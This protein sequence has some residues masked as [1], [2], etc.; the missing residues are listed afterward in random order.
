MSQRTE[1]EDRLSFDADAALDRVQDLYHLP[2]LA[3]LLAYMLWIRVQSWERFFVNDRVLFNG[4]DA[5]YHFRTTTY[6]VRNWPFTMPFDP[7]TYFPYGT[8]SGQFGTFYDQ[9]VA[10]AA[11]VVGVFYPGPQTEATAVTLLFAPAVIGALT[12]IPGYYLGKHFGGRLGGVVAVIVLALTPGAFLWRSLV[13]FSDHHAAEALFQALAVL[14]V[15]VAVAVAE[16]DKPIYEQ[17]V[18]RDF[19]ALRGTLLYA[20]LAGVAVAT[21]VWVWPPG[22]L[23]VAIL[24]AFFLV[25]LLAT[26]LRGRS[27]EHVAI[28]GIVTLVVAALLVSIRVSTL[29]F[30]ATDFSL[31]QP[32]LLLALAAG[33]AVMIVLAR[34]LEARDASPL[35]YPGIILGAIAVVV[36][37][38]AVATP[39]LFDYFVGQFLRVFG[40]DVSAEARTVGE[41]QPVPRDQWAEF[42]F[43]SYGLAYFAAATGAAV[44]VGR[45]LLDDDP[46]GEG[47]LV[48][49]WIVLMTLATFTQVRFDY[50]LAVPVATLTAV[51]VGE[52]VRFVGL[53]DVSR[54]KNVDAAQAMVVASVVLILVVPFTAGPVLAG[55][56]FQA[57]Q[58]GTYTGPG[59]VAQWEGSLQW[60]ANNT[61]EEGRYDNPDGEAM[62]YYGTYDRVENFDYEERYPGSYGVLSWWDYGHYITVEGERIPNANPFQQGATYAADFLLAPNETY[63]NELAT[64]GEQN[65]RYVMI[66][67][68]LADTSSNKYFA[69]AVFDTQGV[70]LSDL[71][72]YVYGPNGRPVVTLHQERHY[73]SMRVRLFTFHGSA[74]SP[75]LPD[76]R[77]P[78]VDWEPRT[79]SNGRTVMSTPDNAS[80]VVRF[81]DSMAE[82]KQFVREDGTAQIGG[83]DGVPTKRIPAL[84]H[85][86]LVHASESAHRGTPWVKTFERV[87]GA[88]VTG[89]GPPNATVT[90]RVQMQMPNG[91][92]FTY[93][94]QAQT[95]AQGNFEMTL[96]YSTTGYD[97][98]GPEQGRTNV[99]VRATGPYEFVAFTQ[100][101]KGNTS[102]ATWNATADVSEAKVIGERD[103]PVRVTLEKSSVETPEGAGTGNATTGANATAGTTD[104]ANATSGTNVTGANATNATGEA[105]AT[106]AA[107]L[108][109]PTVS[110]TSALA[111]AETHIPLAG[112]A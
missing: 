23:I 72:T 47:L 62:K 35:L 27:P 85:Y 67:W 65:T 100:E 22:I 20:T 66:D 97:Q 25:H 58:T 52:V 56:V 54:A 90:A 99:S 108:P 12:A 1:R 93:A 24:G 8:A 103:G 18:Q 32:A 112:A 89:D 98:W 87:P 40:L 38:M 4:N 48:I 49:V 106:P 75:R 91:E 7:W 68:K 102:V 34:R 73:E 64:K 109:A 82:A 39:E 69:P 80:N 42:L 86:R 36:G 29:E 21:Y 92:T 53:D 88:N 14:G 43:R 3:L 104:G 31:L 10:T 57:T 13:G 37:L 105:N 55:P 26:F 5:W 45:Y 6:T 46:R 78:V 96:P 74:A 95:D 84:E 79:L 63:A 19:D 71:Y 81:F 30:T 16:R 51:L 110:V 61:P 60:L 28:A 44:V 77:V 9:L 59:E 2:V 111:P 15:V 50:Y 41:A 83:L 94:Q 11:I 17:F 70:G 33:L 107:S 76:G 101:G